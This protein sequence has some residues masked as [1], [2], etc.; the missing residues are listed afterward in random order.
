MVE[1]KPRY[2]LEEISID[3]GKG[4]QAKQLSTL[5]DEA[6]FSRNQYLQLATVLQKEVI[7]VLKLSKLKL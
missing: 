1:S 6:N 4:H 7:A 5:R 3:S 2:A